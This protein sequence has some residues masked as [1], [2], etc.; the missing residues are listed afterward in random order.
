[1]K[2]KAFFELIGAVVVCEL[3]GIVGSVFTPAAIPTW[4]AALQKPA[5]NP[6]GWIFGPVWVILYA[7]MGVAAFLVWQKRGRKKTVRRALIIFGTQLI[8][9]AAWSILFF[10]LHWPGAALADIILLW[11][12][13]VATIFVFAKISRPAAWLLVPYILWVSFA[14][15]LNYA[16]FVLN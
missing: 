2:L 16:I 11:L 12:G 5:L 9:N 10:G 3:A 7:L 6:P 4:Y 14:A 15:Y 1:M 13:I 8:F